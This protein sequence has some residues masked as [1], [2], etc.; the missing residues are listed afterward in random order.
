MAS[1]RGTVHRSYAMPTS[2]NQG[3]LDQISAL[4]PHWQQ[5][6]HTVEWEMLTRFWETGKL[7]RYLDT[8]ELSTPLTQRHLKSVVNQAYTA[9]RSW[10][11][12]LQLRV[13]KLITRLDY[14]P[15]VKEWLYRVNARQ[16]WF[17]R[18]L[19]V[20]KKVAGQTVKA[21]VPVDVLAEAA[22][23]A[24]DAML[25]H[26]FPDL[27][28][29]RTMVL[30]LPVAQREAPRQSWGAY[31]FRVTTLTKRRPV[32]LPMHTYDRAEQAKGEWA[33][34]LQAHVAEDDQVAFHMVKASQAAAPRED[35]TTAGLDWGLG[36]M[37]ATSDG[38][39]LGLRLYDWLQARD[40]ELTTLQSSLQRQ[41]VPLKTNKRYQ[42]LRHRIRA[43]VTNEVGRI[44]NHLADER[45][46]ELVVEKLDFRAGGL[47]RRMNRLV[48][49]AGRGAIERKLDDLAET[50]GITITHVNPAYTS[51]QC[52]G[53]GFTHRLNRN[54]R[55]FHCRFCGKKRHADIDAARVVRGR[56]LNQHAWCY[57]R[58]GHVKTM[59]DDA[60]H[61]R[62]GTLPSVVFDRPPGPGGLRHHSLPSQVPG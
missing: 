60:F 12:V 61:R 36:S 2:A 4:L 62:W 38:R 3:K 50:R 39:L 54:G 6:L 17:R 10:C 9:L 14:N 20:T 7:P 40:R 55:L 45:I 28:A 47:S 22:V 53:C 25:S 30:D 15:N 26:P 51:Q 18:E 42:A 46:R 58:R 49:T 59:L 24:Q 29:A 1:T 48:Q 31:W 43:H 19:E 41:G 52:S 16:G 8:K 57:S 44:L 5:A 27:G 37:F 56:S 21:R 34:V 35:G 23:L 11:G 32:R 13:R 33:P